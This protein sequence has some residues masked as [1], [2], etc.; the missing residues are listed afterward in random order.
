MCRGVSRTDSSHM[1]S[2]IVM[3]PQLPY[4]CPTAQMTET[5]RPIWEKLKRESSSNNW[6][7][8]W[9]TLRHSFAIPRLLCLPSHPVI[10]FSR[11][12][13]RYV[14]SV[15]VIARTPQGS[16]NVPSTKSAAQS[17][18]CT[19]AGRETRAWHEDL[20]AA[21]WLTYLTAFPLLKL[22]DGA[23]NVTRWD[24]L[25]H[26]WKQ[27]NLQFTQFDPNLRVLLIHDF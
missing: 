15:T 19:H 23:E 3:Y 4:S 16:V 12:Q 6:L 22:P 9:M 24:S 11:L 21:H 8:V 10:W 1:Y 2:L 14:W 18:S 26:F 17:P 5:R 13:A 27:N 25:T 7:A 20:P